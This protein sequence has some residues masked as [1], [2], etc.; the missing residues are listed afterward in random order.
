[1]GEAY[2]ILLR[3]ST[4]FDNYQRECTVRLTCRQTQEQVVLVN[5][6]KYTNQLTR[7]LGTYLFL[8][9]NSI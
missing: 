7:I 8:S 4:V 9:T 5:N 2:P 1:M 3:W 6:D